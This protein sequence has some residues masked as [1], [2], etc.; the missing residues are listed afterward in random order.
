MAL[1][2]SGPELSA[3]P[4]WE[5]L[6]SHL[7]SKSAKPFINQLSPLQNVPWN[8]SLIYLYFLC[9]PAE[10]RE[11]TISFVTSVRPSVR[12]KWMGSHLT[13]YHE[14]WHLSSFSKI[15]SSFS[16][17]CQ[18]NSGVIKIVHEKWALYM[19]TNIHFFVVPPSVLLRMKNVPNRSCTKNKKHILCSITF[20]LYRVIYEVMWKSTVKQDRPHMTHMH[21]MLYT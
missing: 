11:T 10:L 1:Q 5:P 18:E 9:V 2:P 16:K 12:M 20:F 13:D 4:L 17:I 15:L 14:I 19:K 7:W 8:V 21:F 3:S 6:I